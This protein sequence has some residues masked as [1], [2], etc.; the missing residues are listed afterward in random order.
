MKKKSF[1]FLFC[2][3]AGVAAIS[4]NRFT[5]ANKSYIA[6]QDTTPL[7]ATHVMLAF[8]DFAPH[9]KTWLQN[10]RQDGYNLLW[11]Y[12]DVYSGTYPL[13]TRHLLDTAKA[14]GL[15]VMLGMPGGAAPAEIMQMIIDT[16]NHP[17]VFRIK[18]KPVYSIYYYKQSAFQTVLDLL[19]QHGIHK[20]D[21][22]LWSSLLYPQNQYW[23]GPDAWA[24]NY[25]LLENEKSAHHVYDYNTNLDGV[26]NFSVD[27]ATSA[28]GLARE[29]VIF[30]NTTITRV[31]RAR[32]KLTMVGVS[33]LYHS[34]QDWDLGFS[35]ADSIWRAIIK[36]PVALRPE[37]VC[38]VTANDYKELSYMSRLEAPETNGLSYLPPLSAGFTFGNGAR[39]PLLDHSGIQK[40][41][42]PYIEAYKNKKQAIKITAD[43][44]FAWYPLHP[45][46]VA[47][48]NAIPAELSSY[49]QITQGFWNS[50][51]YAKTP[52]W[53]SDGKLPNFNK[54]RMA[55]HLKAPAKLVINGTV[56]AAIYPAGIAFFEIPLAMGTPVFKIQRNGVDVANVKGQQPITNNPWPGGWD[57]LIQQLY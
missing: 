3:V 5:A 17:A 35:G 55:V 53:V 30:E 10:L 14:A 49:K 36:T 41:F 37:A 15:P 33:M 56:S 46:N 2:I 48:S 54:I 50:S 6:V 7:Y 24:E 16:R 47:P 57:Y 8:T 45:R 43:H 40:F 52:A 44:I 27:K 28:D 20:S 39:I 22:V 21:F 1:L 42:K 51:P 23:K 19:E 34:V 29:R 13:W 9:Y 18:N 4:S 12:M 32:R 11:G 31:G 38:D 25:S 26:I